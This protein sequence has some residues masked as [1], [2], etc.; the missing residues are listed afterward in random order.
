MKQKPAVL[1]K[2]LIVETRVFRIE[3]VDLAFSNGEQ[4]QFE[5]LLGSAGGAVLIVPCLD[6]ST[7][8]LVREY[9]VGV[10]RYELGFPKGLMDEGESPQVAADREL[11]EEIGYGSGKLTLLKTLSV[12]PGYANFTTHI[13]L[14]ED[15]YPAKLPGDEPEPLEVVLWRL[16]D[17]D[18]LLARDDFVEA[19]SIAALYLFKRM[20]KQK[21]H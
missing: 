14:A 7:I 1:H 17:L 3:R 5:R 9:G 16:D 11:K 8:A 15:L 20:R 21:E 6:D 18:R 19:R 10:E 2:Q 4:V 12:A 13:V